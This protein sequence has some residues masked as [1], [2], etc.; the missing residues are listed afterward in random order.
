MKKVKRTKNYISLKF[1]VD[2]IPMT[3]IIKGGK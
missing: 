1:R 2:G 3:Q